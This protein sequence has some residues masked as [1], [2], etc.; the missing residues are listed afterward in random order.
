MS[1]TAAQALGYR[2]L[3]DHLTRG[4]PLAEAV[5]RAVHRTARFARRQRAWFRRDPRIAWLDLEPGEDANLLVDA[6]AR[7]VG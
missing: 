2:E 1:R 3:H 4:L 7:T 6:L 5:E